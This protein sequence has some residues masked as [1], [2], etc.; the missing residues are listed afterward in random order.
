MKRKIF[1]FAAIIIASAGVG[2]AADAAAN[3]GPTLCLL[4][5]QRRQR[6]HHDGKK[7]GRERLP[8]PRSRRLQRCRSGTSNQRWR[9]NNGKEKMKPFGDKLSDADVKALGGLRSFL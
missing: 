1:F 2:V 8:M 7:I 5:R 6:E 9:K 4:P 3:V